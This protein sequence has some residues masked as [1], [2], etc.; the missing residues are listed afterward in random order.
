M[1]IA[2]VQKK[3]MGSSGSST[4]H[5][6]TFDSA[7]TQ[8]SLLVLCISADTTVSSVPGW[9]LADSHVGY[10]GCYL[11]Y[12]L[13]GSS[14]SSTVT[15]NIS[16]STSCCLHVFEYSGITNETP[17]DKTDA[18]GGQGISTSIVAGPMATTSQNDELIVAL[19]GMSN[20]ITSQQV[21]SWSNS[22]TNE[23]QTTGLGATQVRLSTATR[24]VNTTGTY[25]TT[26]TLNTNGSTNDVSVI[27]SFKA[28]DPPG[29]PDPPPGVTVAWLTA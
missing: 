11:Y 26:A 12:K 6:V 2:Q 9:T 25:G 8:Y 14:E 21:T 10:V 27:A 19:A 13:A 1:A 20:D 28:G 16:S 4:T 22:F 29:P 3:L 17:L 7:P 23:G 18:D 5:T 15:V 24:I